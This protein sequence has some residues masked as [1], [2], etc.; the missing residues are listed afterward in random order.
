MS[1]LKISNLDATHGLLK[2]VSDFSLT[3]EDGE[4]IALVG[5]NGAGKTT[6]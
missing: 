6:C 1:L 5:A 2:A 3:I 4:K